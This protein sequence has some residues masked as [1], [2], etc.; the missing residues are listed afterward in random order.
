MSENI[1]SIANGT[2]VIGQTSATNFV[3]GPGIKVDSPSEGTVRIS[4]DETVLWSGTKNLIGD[5]IQLSESLNNF[6]E[7]AILHCDRYEIDGSISYFPR[8]VSG[9]FNWLTFPCCSQFMYGTAIYNRGAELSANA[10]KD[11]FTIIGS[12][13]YSVNSGGPYGYT[14][15]TANGSLGQRNIYKVIG[16]NRISR[17]NT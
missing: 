17:S 4:N 8:T 3:G 11:T 7:I 16:I 13:N 5:T 6:N 15:I 10:N 2:Y 1:Q 12:Y 14:V 9:D